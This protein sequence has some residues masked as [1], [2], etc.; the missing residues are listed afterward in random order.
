MS[1]FINSQAVTISPLLLW[2][3]KPTQVS[4][5]ETYN[6]DIWPVSSIL[7]EGPI[8]FSIPPQSHGMLFSVDIITRVQLVNDDEG[9]NIGTNYLNVGV[10]NNFANSLWEMVE[11][12][13]DDRTD[14]MQSMRNAYPYQSFFNHALNNESTHAQY[15]LQNELF[16]MDQGSSKLPAEHYQGQLLDIDAI[17]RD[18]AQ[19]I[20]DTSDDEIAAFNYSL[21]LKN[22]IDE[23]T[24]FTS[25]YT[26]KTATN[27]SIYER[28][29]ALTAGRSTTI[30]SRLQCPLFTTG[31]CLPTN[32][33]IRV[34][35]S[36]NTD[37]FLLM[38]DPVSDFYKMYKVKVLDVHLQV[39]YYRPRDE[40]L[41]K[42]ESKLMLEP[43]SYFVS[44]PELI[45][46]PILHNNRIIRVANLFNEKLPTHA[47]FCLQKSSDFDGRRG[48]SPF[49]FIPFNKFQLHV[50]GVPHFADPLETTYSTVDG[51]KLYK[52][53][54]EY[55]RQLY[56]TIG[57]DLKGDCLINSDN[58]PLNFIV[59]IS[60]TADKSTT[61]SNYLNLQ[62][63]GTVTLEIDVGYDPPPE[64]M[65]LIVYALFDRQI[66]IDHNRSLRIID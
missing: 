33:R 8:T 26:N 49:I 18:L 15:L 12:R 30:S 40:I 54:G 57:K 17:Y 25:W 27:P 21:T 23:K 63:A 9:F 44:K 50:N 1:K 51:E 48:T 34:S 45:V 2:E 39:S 46:M 3:E 37:D 6:L 43:A 11:V 52:N 59:G 62:E 10:I 60:F 53:T 65:I 4:V 7:G 19:T 5:Q 29:K 58:F 22:L 38:T 56:K 41:K 14:L 42:I 32:M 20:A 55:M 66:Q 13:V 16:M 28:S 61:S 35:L 47:F 64:D 36:K 31:K 24:N